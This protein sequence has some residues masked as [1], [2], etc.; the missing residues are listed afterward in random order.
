MTF[1]PFYAAEQT[2]NKR[3]CSTGEIRTVTKKFAFNCSA[4]EI[5]K[6]NF[7]FVAE[8]LMW[9]SLLDR[10]LDVSFIVTSAKILPLRNYTILSRLRKIIAIDSYI[11]NISVFMQGNV[12]VISLSF[13]A[14]AGLCMCV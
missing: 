11:N 9:H 10:T 3:K 8:K 5:Y 1:H 13:L 12:S 6:N 14:R 7:F 4:K 2:A